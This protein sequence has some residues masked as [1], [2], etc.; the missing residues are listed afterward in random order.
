[1]RMGCVASL[2]KP[3]RHLLQASRL[4]VCMGGEETYELGLY[5]PECILLN[6]Q[7]STGHHTSD[8]YM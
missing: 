6:L 4:L 2:Q 5:H 8:S 7:V 1:M 3:I